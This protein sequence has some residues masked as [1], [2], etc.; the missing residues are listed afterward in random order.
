MG[1]LDADSLFANIFPWSNHQI[2]TNDQFVVWKKG[3]HNRKIQLLEEIVEG[4]GVCFA[5]C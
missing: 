5:V 2:C 4:N 1:N 3:N